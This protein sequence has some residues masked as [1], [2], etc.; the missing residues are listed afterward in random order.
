MGIFATRSPH[1]PNPIGLSLAKLEK[2]EGDTIFLSGIDLVNGTPVLDVKPYLPLWDGAE[3]ARTGWAEENVFPE[4]EVEFTEKAEEDIKETGDVS[5]RSLISD[6]LR[7]DPR[8]RRDRSQMGENHEL[9]FFISNHDIHFSVRGGKATVI[10]VETGKTF[11]KKFRRG[12]N[13]L[14]D[15]K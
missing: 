13:S 2:I 5:L 7:Q 12:K 4:L 3:N 9:G 10:S 15:S 11:V 6:T 1:R 14:K 8:N